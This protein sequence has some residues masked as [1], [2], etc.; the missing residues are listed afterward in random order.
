MG[1]NVN[2]HNAIVGV[3]ANTRVRR[4]CRC[5]F[6]PARRPRFH[7]RQNKRNDEN[8]TREQVTD[9]KAIAFVLNASRL[10]T[11]QIAACKCCA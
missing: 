8:Y 11:P 1:R 6:G 7:A 2:K 10:D 9:R 5:R 3:V 4:W